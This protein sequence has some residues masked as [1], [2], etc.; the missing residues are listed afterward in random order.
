LLQGALVPQTMYWTRALHPTPAMAGGLPKH[1][2]ATLF[3]CADGLWMHVMPDPN[4][5]PEVRAG[6]AAMSAEERAAA[7]APFR[8]V[9]IRWF[10][11]RGAVAPVFRS[12]P[13]A[14]WLRLLWAADVPAEAVQPMGALYLDEQVQANGYAQAVDCPEFGPVWQ[15]A[16]PISCTTPSPIPSAVTSAGPSGTPDPGAASTDT[17]PTRPAQRHDTLPLQGL[18]VLDLGSYVAGPLAPMILADLGADVIKVEAIEGD[19]MR[20]AEWPFMACQ[21]GKRSIAINLKDPASAPLLERLVQWADVVHHNQRPPAARKLGIDSDRL[22]A[23]NPAVIYAHVSAYGP[24]GPRRDWPGYDQLFQAA[25]GW[26]NLGAGVGNPPM[27]HRFGMMDHLAALWSVISVLLALRAREADGLGRHSDSSLLGASLFTMDAPLR[28]DGTLVPTAEIDEL[29]WG[30][31]PLRRLYACADGWIAV[32]APAGAAVGPGL[33]RLLTVAGTENLAE[34]EVRLSQAPCAAGLAL[35]EA[36]GLAAVTVRCEGRD[37]F[38]DDPE[39]LASRLSTQL[40]HPLYGRLDMPGAMMDFDGFAAPCSTLPPPP[41]GGHSRAILDE[42]GFSTEDVERW[43]AQ[44]LV[45]A[46]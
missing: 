5:C 37:T 6:L 12:R 21:R 20:R 34:L 11:N 26:E 18:K 40:P 25:S 36:A 1:N 14:E 15:P 8:Q 46:A 31:S 30:E 10:D 35:M 4:R 16:L 41:L 22:L 29:Q 32:S 17:G 28:H 44:G 33:D 7:D 43:I 19:P 27:W 23:M 39:H 2:P 42:L 9:P 38:L 24:D 13:R 3:E 45:L